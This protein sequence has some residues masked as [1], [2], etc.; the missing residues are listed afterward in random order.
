MTDAKQ[1]SQ[2]LYEQAPYIT[3][4]WLDMRK[5]GINSIYAADAG[6]HLE[7]QLREHNEKLIHAI[8]NYFLYD[9]QTAHQELK[10]W[11]KYV[12]EL[13][14]NGQVPIHESL[15]QFRLF[16]GILWDKVK[17]FLVAQGLDLDTALLYGQKINDA[18]DFMILHF[19][20]HYDETYSSQMQAQQNLINELSS[21]VIPITTKEAILPLIG[22]LDS[23]RTHY[24]QKNTLEL[25]SKEHYETLYLDMSGVHTI[26]TVVA[27]HLF[28][29]IQSLE[30]LG[31]QSVI[32]GM[33]PKVA[34]VSIQLGIDFSK[35][36]VK[37]TLSHALA[38]LSYKQQEEG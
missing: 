16:R 10:D 20:K 17:G 7:R 36:P 29:L 18:Y 38:D 33:K 13:R 34:Q 19:V 5:K 1:L 9:E 24:I 3:Q 8:I 15:E 25:C 23:N 32:C 4:E 21:P 14:V 37:S 28:Q 11:A 27:Q 31:I 6:D 30:L 35:I 22:D 26:D 2:Y 12:S